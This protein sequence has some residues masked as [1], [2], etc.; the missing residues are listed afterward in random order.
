[1][2]R[3]WPALAV[4]AVTLVAWTCVWA[5]ARADG[6]AVGQPGGYPAGGAR[7]VLNGAAL[8]RGG[9]PRQAALMAFAAPVS[10]QAARS[11]GEPEFATDS[12]SVSPVTVEVSASKGEVTV[13]ETFALEV[14]ASGPPG[15]EYTFPA[16]ASEEAFE[17][18]T[19]ASDGSGEP[20]T[21]APAP[22]VHRYEAA[23]FALGTVS[24]P[25]I[26]VRYRLPD[27]TEGQVETEPVT[28]EVVS[29]LPKDQDAQKLVD[30]RGPREAT[31]GRAF[32]IAV[33]AVLVLVAALAAWIVR[34]RRRPAGRAVEAVVPD[35]PPDVEARRALADLASARLIE[36]GAFRTFYIRLTAIAKR[37]LE[38]RLGAPVLEMTTSESLAFLR[39]HEHGA[40]VLPVMKDLA[41]AA[42]RIKF[43]RGQG[44]RPEAQQHLA[45]VRALV[46]ALEARL[47][48]AA[49]EAPEQGRAA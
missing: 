29:M 24:L 48:P 4:R 2:G 39:G 34:R 10:P 36:G 43:A 44:L 25:P 23:V 18:T 42:D 20:G 22:G 33:V 32:W 1:V 27:G 5:T 3:R 21:K 37:Y 46:P 49:P 31:V 30:V 8:L 9:L 38:R 11:G 45:A 35:L 15:T 17:L 6:L 7:A 19:P 16:G 14:T 13:G 40:D 41:E 28:V 26:P 12:E 47:R